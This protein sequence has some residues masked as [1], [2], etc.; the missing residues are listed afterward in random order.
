MTLRDLFRWGNRF[1]TSQNGDSQQVLADQGYFLL[2]TRCRNKQDEVTVIE[3]LE[4]VL[5]QRVELAKLFATDSQYLTA[6]LDPG[7]VVMTLDMR[8]MLVLCSEAWKC[9]EP[10]LFVSETGSGKTTAAHILS[11]GRLLSINCHERTETSALLGSIRPLSDGTLQW[12]D[13]VIVLSSF[14]F[15]NEVNL[16]CL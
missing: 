7:R 2:G 16:T 3:V 15:S 9:D 14:T 1:R 11:K 13:R 10:V 6:N 12:Q 5:K 8:R 4:K